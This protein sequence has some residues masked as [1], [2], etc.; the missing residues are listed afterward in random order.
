MQG[1]DSVPSSTGPLGSSGHDPFLADWERKH[2][3]AGPGGAGAGV[4][5][6]GR[7]GRPTDDVENQYRRIYEDRVNPFADF[8]RYGGGGSGVMA[9]WLFSLETVLSWE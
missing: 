5:A 3:K 7:T 2:G 9:G 4:G 8:N 1:S 6:G